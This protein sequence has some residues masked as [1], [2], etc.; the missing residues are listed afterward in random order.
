MKKMKMLL[1][2]C[3]LALCVLLFSACASAS[4]TANGDPSGVTL[5]L[6]ENVLAPGEQTAVSLSVPDSAKYT[7]AVSAAYGTISG[8]DG[9]LVYTAPDVMPPDSVDTLTVTLTTGSDSVTQEAYALVLDDTLAGQWVRTGG[10]QGGTITAIEVDPVNHGVMYAAGSGDRLFKTLDNGD[11]W[12]GLKIDDDRAAGVFCDIKIDT[13]DSNV[14]Y[15]LNYRSLIVSMDAGEHWAY[16]IDGD[17]AS[18]SVTA[19]APGLLI[20]TKYDGRVLR[21]TDCCA[22]FTDIT[23]NLP[24]E[25][26]VTSLAVSASELWVGTANDG[27]GRIYK[28]TDGGAHWELMPLDYPSPAD[29]YSLYADP[30]DPDTIYL[31]FKNSQ[32]E[33]IRDADAGQYLQKTTDGGRTWTR[34]TIPSGDAVVCVL[35]IS[36]T[37]TLFVSAGGTVYMS[38]DGG[39]S[40]TKVESQYVRN[41]DIVDIGFDTDDP[42]CIFI[43][44]A[45]SGIMKSTDGG[46]TWTLKVQGLDNLKISLLAMP[47]ARQGQTVY[48]SSVGGEGIF[49]TVDFGRTWTDIMSDPSI[50]PW[51]DELQINPAGA[52]E[53]WYIADVGD[54][55]VTEDGGETWEKRINPSGDGQRFGSVYALAAAQCDWDTLYAL[56]SGF[57]LFKTTDKGMS[58]TFLDQS[59]IDYTYTLAI[60][61]EN[62]DIV[63]SGYNP[64]P[65][66][67]FAMIRKT[68]DGGD[69]W[70]TSLEIE[71]SDGITSVVLD[72]S[73]PDTVYAGSIGED[74]GLW[75]SYNGGGSWNRLCESL[76]FTNVHT[77]AADPVQ[78]DVAYAGVWGGGTWKTLD[79]GQSWARLANDPT[80]S[81]IAI[82]IDS[83]HTD[84][85]YLADR[86]TPRVY[87]TTGD[88][89]WT[90]W[91]DAGDGYYRILAAAI[92]PSDP[93][94]LYVSALESG[95]AFGGMLFRIENGT[96]RP[97]GEALDRLPVSIAVDPADADHLVVVAHA[98]GVYESFT[99]GADWASL[100]DSAQGLPDPAEMSYN[101][102]QFDP[103]DSGTLYLLGGGD[104][105]TMALQSSGVSADTVNTVYRSA[106]GGRT[107]KNLND[108]HLGANSGGV[109]G[110][111]VSG[112]DADTL[113]IGCTNGIF[114]SRDNGRTWRDAGETLGYRNTAGIALSADGKTLYAP[115]LGG[116]VYAGTVTDGGV[117]WQGESAL[118]VYINHIQVLVDPERSNVLYASAYPGGIFKS[119][120]GGATFTE[121]NFGLP[122]FSVED[123]LRQ[124]YYAIQIA[125]SNSEILY[126][127]VYGKGVYVSR[128]GAGTWLAVNG[129]DGIM[130]SKGIYSLAVDTCDSAMVTVATEE[131]VFRTADGGQ[132]WT[133]LSGGLPDDIQVRIL[134]TGKDNQ[135]FAGTLGYEVYRYVPETNGWE[136]LQAFSNFG[137]FWPIWNERPLYQ[138]TYLL[139]NE[140]DPDLVLIGTF[141]A[142]IYRSTDGGATFRE[143]NVNWTFD[144]VFYM[145]YHPEDNSIIYAGTYNGVNRSLDQGLTWEMWDT[146]WPDEQ[147]VFSI[148]F[149][150][151]DP[152]IMYACSKNGEN[153][154]VGTPEFGGTVM[155]STDGGATWFSI[156]SNLDC[157]QEFYKII[158][159]RN[160]PAILYLAT[161]WDGVCISRNAGETW[162]LWDEGLTNRVAGVNGNNVTNTMLLSPDGN[163]LYFGTAGDGVFR[164][165]SESAA[166]AWGQ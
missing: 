118:R 43:P 35:G 100:S 83:Q 66:Q 32:N 128:D 102:V 130:R 90:T 104:V 103:S 85:V 74:P 97:V 68:E 36:E 116:G 46:A 159:D 11:T 158:V 160:D 89:R 44:T 105:V 94:V 91:F 4:A 146:G 39:G 120:D 137:V 62:A 123:P 45:R 143:S 92:A 13:A 151:N 136:Q 155:K 164:R 59:E 7:C 162:E 53:L 144:G 115:M 133:P 157:T 156:T 127:G 64:K 12:R 79:G 56:K 82:L 38:G 61:P 153:E 30:A 40:W 107:W 113:Y 10:P 161:E 81:A 3:A 1:I 22:S 34:L 31:S 33:M 72:P 163:L 88:G 165:V 9:R 110:L 80:D 60:H 5:T 51:G 86:M 129:A 147:W 65:F 132:S 67:D 8:M 21:S 50:H 112:I 98:G 101:A 73:D 20:V 140:Q 48:V 18:I 124:G 141:P 166:Q 99:G 122:S 142:G 6:E 75:A 131:G 15:A 17:V 26:I 28:T 49:K 93:S 135:L 108:G 2:P 78:P 58:W 95:S 154:G 52:D 150:P 41:G 109:K 27:N 69:T 55:Y 14:I 19:G 23:G 71:G 145:T 125:P 119:T 37:G 47:L 70:E 114:I 87:K 76:T 134:V 96:A 54:V 152:D 42:D 121:Q 138:Y 25:E 84:T 148:D 63:Y 126:L 139:F 24:Q 111:S 149:D 57:G 106:D 16:A 117:R 29:S 77:M